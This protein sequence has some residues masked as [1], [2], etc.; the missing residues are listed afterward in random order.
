MLSF[1]SLTCSSTVFRLMLLTLDHHKKAQ[2]FVRAIKKRKSDLRAIVDENQLYKGPTASMGEIITILAQWGAQ[3]RTFK[4]PK[5]G[6]NAMMHRKLFLARDARFP[7]EMT[8]IIRSAKW[9]HN[10][11]DGSHLQDS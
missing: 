6:M 2:A 4:P 9:T 5:G 10:N 7:E 8:T 11:L 3:I 1:V